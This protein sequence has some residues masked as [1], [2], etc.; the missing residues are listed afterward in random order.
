VKRDPA[1]RTPVF[2]EALEWLVAHRP[3][4]ERLS[5]CWG[6]AKI[7]NVLYDPANGDVS[8]LL[9]WEM[10]RIGDP[11]MDLPSLHLSTCARRRPRA[12]HSKGRR[13]RTSSSRCTRPRAAGASGTSTTSSCS[14]RSGAA[15]VAARVHAPDGGRGQ[16]DRA[17]LQAAAASRRGSC[18]SCWTFLSPDRRDAELSNRLIGELAQG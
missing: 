16:R 6:D 7:G 8:A 1:E 13:A 14:R 17:R 12:A 9:D 10:A 18:A 15:A 5:L 11:E 2:D 4:P 3:E